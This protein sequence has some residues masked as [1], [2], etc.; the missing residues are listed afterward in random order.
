[1]AVTIVLRRM[2]APAL[3]AALPAQANLIVNGDFEACAIVTAPSG[4][5]SALACGWT[6]SQ[7]ARTFATGG[8]PGKRVVL[9]SGGSNLSDPAAWQTVSGLV[10]GTTYQLSWDLDLAVHFGGTGGSGRSFGVFLDQQDLAHNLFFG[11]QLTDG[12]VSHQLTF[13]ATATSHTLIFAAELDSRSNGLTTPPGND[14]DVSHNIDNVR[15]VGLAPSSNVGEPGGLAL[16]LVAL[17]AIALAR[18]RSQSQ[19]SR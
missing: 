4:G 14:T 11:E 7:N 13:V 1:M 17:G 9:E 15:L 12:W 2:I 18:R 6:L 8:N 10:I 5:S 3:F 19:R 16:G